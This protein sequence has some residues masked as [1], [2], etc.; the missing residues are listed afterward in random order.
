VAINARLPI[1]QSFMGGPKVH[2]NEDPFAQLTALFHQVVGTIF[3]L[4]AGT[5]IFGVSEVEQTHG[6]FW[7]QR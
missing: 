1:C 7:C 5:V 2:R 3:D 4:M 6:H